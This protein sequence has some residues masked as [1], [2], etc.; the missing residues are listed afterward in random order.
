MRLEFF[1]T[2]EAQN[3]DSSILP[4][5]DAAFLSYNPNWQAVKEA[6][7]QNEKYKNILVIGHGGS[8]TSFMGMYEA[9]KSTAT[10]QAYFLS[11]VDPDYIA[12][13]KAKINPEDTLVVAISK[14]GETTTQIE[15]LMQFTDYPLLFVTGKGSALE[16]I[17]EKLKAQVFEHPPIGGR[18]TAFTE[19]GVLPAMLCGLP[20]EEMHAGAK[21]MYSLYKKDNLAWKAASVLF[22][23]EERGYADVFLPFYSKALYGFSNLIVQLCHE[24]FGKAGKGQTYAA[25][26]APESQHHTN[27]RFFG[28]PKNMAGFFVSQDNFSNHAITA[29]PTSIQSVEMKGQHLFVLNK[30]PL[31][32]AMQF[33]LEG[34]MEDAK[35]NAIPL[36]HMSLSSLSAK[37]AGSFI[38]FWQMYAVYSSLL[39]QVDPFDQPQ[40]ENSKII[41]FSKR[42]GF[43]GVL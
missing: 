15:A 2:P 21:E 18:Y 12:E 31:A 8:I 14:S 13:L 6:V 35:I 41:S 26:E 5:A 10:K 23:L 43:K 17:A 29:V 11:S 20:V 24:S 34:T 42:L 32:K 1:N 40:V 27:Q 38:A 28:G 7:K 22:Q 37:E 3:F 19:V 39:R 36:A 30:I 25:F 9:F 33:E 16:K 4:Q